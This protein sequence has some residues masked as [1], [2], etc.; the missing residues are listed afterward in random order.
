M[1]LQCY[2]HVCTYTWRCGL[3]EKHGN[4]RHT[5]FCLGESAVATG[6][7][8]GKAIEE[9]KSKAGVSA[10]FAWQHE[11]CDELR[12][13]EYSVHPRSVEGTQAVQRVGMDDD[14]GTVIPLGQSA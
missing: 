6:G 3:R 14:G 12:G 4:I 5:P 13:L 11:R 10:C 7:R 1:F 8:R 2:M 9:K